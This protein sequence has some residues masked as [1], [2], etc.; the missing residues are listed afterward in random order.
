MV[1]K[2]LWSPSILCKNF[3]LCI[4]NQELPLPKNIKFKRI[5]STIGYFYYPKD[6][7]IAYF[8]IHTLN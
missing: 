6:K 3:K 7:L 4:N 1:E 5:N 2:S 8:F